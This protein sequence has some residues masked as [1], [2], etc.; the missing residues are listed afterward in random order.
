MKILMTCDKAINKASEAQ[1]IRN[2]R[3]PAWLRNKTLASEEEVEEE[4]EE[5]E[6][7]EEEEEEEEEEVT[8][9]ICKRDGTVNSFVLPPSNY[10]STNSNKCELSPVNAKSTTVNFPLQTVEE[11]EEF[12]RNL[13]ESLKVQKFYINEIKMIGGSDA[14]KFTRATLRFL[15]SNQLA[16][17]YSWSGQRNTLKFQTTRISQLIVETI[18]KM[19]NVPKNDIGIF[20]KKWLQH[21]SDRIKKKT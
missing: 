16:I 6:E 1:K 19:K 4:V 11:F 14:G 3:K 17:K 18:S 9:E 7:K 2:R 21:A 15:M 20:V 10:Q 5:E 8:E 12:E 13:V